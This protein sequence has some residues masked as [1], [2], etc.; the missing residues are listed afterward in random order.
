MGAV[1]G[2]LGTAGGANGSGYSAPKSAGLQRGT[3]SADV[4]NA[5]QTAGNTMQHQQSLLN[6]LQSQNGLAQQNSI[7]RQQQGL[8]DQLGQANG[9]GTQSAA[10]QGLQGTAGMYQNIAEGR[11]P[12][13]AQSMLNQQ[14]GQNIANQAAMMAGQR[15]A[16]ANAG[17]IA[18]QAAQQ[19]AATQQQAV[20]QGA[21]MQAQQQQNA[22]AGLTNAQQAFGNIGSTQV[23]QLQGQQG[24]MANQANQI[25]GQ[26]IGQVNNNAQA[27]LANQGQMQGALGGINNAAVSSQASV[28][29]GKAGM[30]GANMQGQQATIGGLLNPAGGM[31]A[32]GGVVAK[33]SLGGMAEQAAPLPDEASA[34]PPPA[35]P[36]IAAPAAEAAVAPQAGAQSIFGQMAQ[37]AGAALQGDANSGQ[38]QSFDPSQQGYGSKKLQQG[39]SNA[40]GKALKYGKD[41]LKDMQSPDM[42][43]AW[44]G[45]DAAGGAE[46]LAGATGAAEGL[47]ALG[48]A[49]AAAEG[50]GLLASVAPLIALAAEGGLAEKGGHVKASGPE[51]KAVASGNDYAN[52]K[53]PAQLSEGEI[54]LPRSVTMSQD[55][56]KAASEFVTKTLKQRAQPKSNF[57]DGTNEGPVEAPV[58]QP[59][60]QAEAPIAPPVTPP[61]DPAAA[62]QGDQ[63]ATMPPQVP[64]DPVELSHQ[65]KMKEMVKRNEDIASGQVTPKTYG[66]LFAEKSTLGK[67]GA[68]FGMM[69]S[70][71]GAGLSHQTPVYMQMMNQ[72]VMNDL[73]A[74]KKNKDNARNFLSLQYE[75]AGKKQELLDKQLETIQ[76]TYVGNKALKALGASPDFIKKFQSEALKRAEEIWAPFEAETTTRQAAADHVKRLADKSGNPA[77]IQAANGVLQGADQQNAQTLQKGKAAVKLTLADMANKAKHGIQKDDSEVINQKVLDAAITDAGAL[78]NKAAKVGAMTKDVADAIGTEAEN[79]RVRRQERNAT[80]DLFDQL[81]KTPGAGENKAGLMAGL[82]KGHDKEGIVSAIGSNFQKAWENKRDALLAPMRKKYGDDFTDSMV[83]GI[84]DSAAVRADK[85]KQLLAFF[86]RQR[87]TPLLNTW[88]S[89]MPKLFNKEREYSSEVKRHEVRSADPEEKAKPKKGSPAERT[90]NALLK[91]K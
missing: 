74:Q 56:V 69:L 80:M 68:I 75:A 63:A 19:G 50:G 13:V 17:L 4:N 27:A 49:G 25:A 31:A 72:A 64:E 84:Y 46:A 78:G 79:E 62:S 10:V 51:E 16:G 88:G 43:G 24:A 91:G 66:D 47:G 23:G 55:P 26:Q 45:A 77:A 57:Y 67:V 44:T 65:E 40:S 89:R 61:A 73:E 12:N 42:A 33:M 54:V 70:G 71:A 38:D 9:V 5:Q 82:F 39:V 58:T 29:A 60:N 2:L 85:K 11:G 30:A 8:A 36:V 32:E 76:N 90:L 18:R 15:G 6:A 35:A 48:T 20:G 52:D 41:L 22:L 34:P 87:H 81:D 59:P 83:P 37:G 28:N 86:E 7:A 14:T 3:T 21:T 53:I 1:S